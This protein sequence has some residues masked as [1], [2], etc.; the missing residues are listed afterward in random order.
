MARTYNEE[1][2]CDICGSKSRVKSFT[3]VSEEGAAVIDLCA[4]DAKPLLKFWQAGSTEPRK[5]LT[6]GGHSR[7]SGHSVTPVD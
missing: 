4:G 5:K 1:L 7:A 2:T 6:G 3:I